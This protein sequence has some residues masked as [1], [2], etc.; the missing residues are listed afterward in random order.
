MMLPEVPGIDDCDYL[1]SCSN[2]KGDE[3]LYLR[4]QEFDHEGQT[5]FAA[6][7]TIDSEPAHYC[8]DLPCPDYAHTKEQAVGWLLESARDRWG[9]G[10]FVKC[11]DT[12]VAGKRL[13]Q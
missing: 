4:L 10:R 7:M 9:K 11:C 13:R 8:A 2:R 5:L 3:S 1:L 6:A 12:R